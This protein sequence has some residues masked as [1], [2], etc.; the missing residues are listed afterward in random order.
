MN[1]KKNRKFAPVEKVAILR[2]HLLEK[3]PVSEICEAHQLQPS[4]FYRWQKQFFEQ[5]AA[6]FKSTK[7]DKAEVTKLKQKVSHLEGRLQ[8]K[9]EVLGELMED[10]VM[11]KK[12]IGGH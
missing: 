12:K 11:L 3:K 10:H 1:K 5:G 8:T 2:L 9:N 4:M 6:A 7:S